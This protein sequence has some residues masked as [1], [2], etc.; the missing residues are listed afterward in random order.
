MGVYLYVHTLFTQQGFQLLAQTGVEFEIVWCQYHARV[1]RPPQN[2]LPFAEP[3]E[4]ASAVRVYQ[5]RDA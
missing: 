4:N 1:C 5:A 3:R 2:G